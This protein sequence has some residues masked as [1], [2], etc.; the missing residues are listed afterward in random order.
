MDTGCAASLATDSEIPGP[1]DI[2]AG[3]TLEEGFILKLFGISVVGLRLLCFRYARHVLL[4]RERCNEKTIKLMLFLSRTQFGIVWN[5]SAS[6][7][8]T[9]CGVRRSATPPRAVQPH[10]GGSI[11]VRF[12]K[13]SEH[14]SGALGLCFCFSEPL[15]FELM[16]S[17]LHP[18]YYCS[19]CFRG[20]F[21]CLRQ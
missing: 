21:G 1:S 2:A 9:S 15:S 16:V 3:F 10:R 14:I 7:P 20:S 18:Y 4:L 11:S 13:L 6:T 12:I 8:L 19:F 17:K 5:S